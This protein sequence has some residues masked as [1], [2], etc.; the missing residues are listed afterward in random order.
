MLTDDERP[1]VFYGEPKTTSQP[2]SKREHEVMLELLTP[3]SYDYMVK[4]IWVRRWSARSA[5]S[6][7][8]T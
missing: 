2:P 8:P 6:S 1:L 5:P 7:R 3:F 4:A